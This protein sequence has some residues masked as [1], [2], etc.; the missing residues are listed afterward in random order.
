[1]DDA[2]DPLGFAELSLRPCA[3][4]CT[5]SPVAY[6]E[7]WYVTPDARHRGVGRRLIEAAEDWGRRQGCGELASDTTLDNTVSAAAH[8]AAGFEDAGIVRCFRKGLGGQAE[9]T[10]PR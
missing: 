6:L 5:T 1:M 2:N 10:K 4:G 3:E 8:G 9:A 7:G